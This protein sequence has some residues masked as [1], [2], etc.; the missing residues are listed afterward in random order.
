MEAA[1]GKRYLPQGEKVWQLMD[2]VAG[3]VCGSYQVVTRQEAE[4]VIGSTHLSLSMPSNWAP[5]PQGSIAFHNSST[6]WRPNIQTHVPLG[7]TSHL[8]RNQSQQNTYLGSWPSPAGTAR[9]VEQPT[10]ECM[11][12]KEASCPVTATALRSCGAVLRCSAVLG[13]CLL[14]LFVPDAYPLLLSC[15]LCFLSSGHWWP[16][17]LCA[18]LRITPSSWRFSVNTVSQRF[19]TTCYH[20]P[21]WNRRA[22]LLTEVS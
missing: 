7:D 4:R 20:S 12:K 1:C 13:A 18:K 3:K 5:P 8:I 22:L 15:A 16:L 9:A 17:F 19:L 10:K 11:H 2:P 6:S 21:L 14:I